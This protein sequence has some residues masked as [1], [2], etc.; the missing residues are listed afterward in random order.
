MLYVINNGMKQKKITQRRNIS[1]NEIKQIV[2][3]GN[4]DIAKHTE[5]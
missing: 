5:T 4:I 1:N 3:R 2:G